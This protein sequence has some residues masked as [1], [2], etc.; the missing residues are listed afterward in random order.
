MEIL[1]IACVYVGYLSAI[2][3]EEK[4]IARIQ[5]SHEK[6]GRTKG[7]GSTARERKEAI[8]GVVAMCDEKHYHGAACERFSAHSS[9]GTED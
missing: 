7:V 9:V 1:L 2:E 8:G 5:E 3:K 4:K 6:C